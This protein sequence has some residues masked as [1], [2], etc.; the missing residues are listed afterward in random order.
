MSVESASSVSAI[1]AELDDLWRGEAHGDEAVLRS[2]VMNLIVVCADRERAAETTTQIA[3]LSGSYPGRAIL[4]LLDDENER[5]TL[6]MYASAHCRRG[7][8]GA[9]VC[10]EQITIEAGPNSRSLLS[11][12]LLQFLVA[13]C[14]VFTWWQ[15]GD[16]AEDP[17][18][19]ELTGL[20][21]LFIL[22]SGRFD[23]PGRSLATLDGLVR[24]AESGVH[25]RDLA[26]KRQEGWREAV[27]AMFDNAAHAG[28]LEEVTRIL[29]RTGPPAAEGCSSVAGAYLA[30]WLG[31]R[32]GW[33]VENGCLRRPDGEAVA[34]RFECNENAGWEE[35]D[36][37]RIEAGEGA[38]FGARRLGGGGDGVRLRSRVGTAS[39]PPS[40]QRVGF[41]DDG[42]LLTRVFERPGRDPLFA[43]A[44]QLAAG[45]AAGEKQA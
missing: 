11:P 18:A 1:E 19:R 26:W 28:L 16:A 5:D 30:G 41:P 8:G 4:V 22:D 43:D 15:A 2:C 24:Q 6:T 25:V 13:D 3:T 32:L 9:Q 29:L 23:K 21:E 17:L 39:S 36:A 12:T 35:I 44:L 42:R 45:I 33:T 20:S 14:P 31:S 27:A 7:A 10:N 38:V 34:L 40:I 37:I